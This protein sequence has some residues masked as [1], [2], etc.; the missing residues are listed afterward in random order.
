[1]S[2]FY[3]P[4]HKPNWRERELMW[5]KVS[6]DLPT[7]HRVVLA[8]IHW[9]SFFIGAAASIMISLASVGAWSV[10]SGI[11]QVQ[12]TVQTRIG[13]AL[14]DMLSTT[15]DVIES[16]SDERRDVLRA[17]LQ[18]ITAID[19][20]IAELENDIEVNGESEIKHSQLRRLYAMKMDFVKELLLSGDT[21]Q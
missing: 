2:E 18:N 3:K 11:N 5:N 12:Q 19:E 16:A 8:A 9:R 1:M 15:P 10:V 20:M 17:Q 7:P 14:D 21:G 6:A 4:E 13:V